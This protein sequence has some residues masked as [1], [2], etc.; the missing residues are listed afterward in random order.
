MGARASVD[1]F[2]GF[3]R[4]RTLPMPVLCAVHGTVLAGGLA[5]CLLTDYVACEPRMATL[6]VGERSRGIYPA[7]LLRRTLADAVGPAC[8]AQPIPDRRQAH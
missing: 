4:L 8:C 2:D 6:Q 3:C 5:V 7:G 1:L